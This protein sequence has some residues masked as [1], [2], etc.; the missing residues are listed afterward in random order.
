M[1]V[2]LEWKYKKWK[3]MI[4]DNALSTENKFNVTPVNIS[5]YKY[6]AKQ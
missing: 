5:N 2:K 6:C 4:I 3:V 1:K